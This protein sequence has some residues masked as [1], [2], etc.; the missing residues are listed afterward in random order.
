[1]LLEFRYTGI[2]WLLIEKKELGTCIGQFLIL[3]MGIWPPSDIQQQ[4]RGFCFIA[5]FDSRDDRG[6]IESRL[7][8]GC[9]A[10]VRFL[11]FVSVFEINWIYD[12][13]T[14]RIL[15]QLHDLRTARPVLSESICERYTINEL[16]LYGFFI[17][18]GP[19]Q[20]CCNRYT[21]Y[22]RT[23]RSILDTLGV[24]DS[25]GVSFIRTMI[26]FLFMGIYRPARFRW[27]VCVVLRNAIRLSVR[28]SMRD[29]VFI[30]WA[31]LECAVRIRVTY[32]AM[33]WVSEELDNV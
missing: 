5:S 1:M 17:C 33:R 7:S 16:W 30:F 6:S 28:C 25:Q 24:A 9:S 8:S 12:L 26:W 14:M 29:D 32:C 18:R 11:T 15:Y 10:R 19:L 23:K 4:S 3:V 20:I 27:C 31:K 21:Y 13:G 22:M 2:G